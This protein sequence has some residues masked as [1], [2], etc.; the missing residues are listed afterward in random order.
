MSKSA[1]KNAARIDDEELTGDDLDQ[2][3]NGSEGSAPETK[4]GLASGGRRDMEALVDAI[5]RANMVIEF[6]LDGTIID[7][8]ENFLEA[9]GYGLDEIVGRN[10][11]MFVDEI[12]SASR[13]YRQLWTDLRR[14]RF[15]SDTFRRVTADGQTVW[16]QASY[17]PVLDQ[18]GRP[19]RIVKLASDITEQTKLRLD[20]LAKLEAI[21]RSQATVEFEP[22]GTI[23][24]ANDNFLSLMGY[25]AAEVLGKH[26]SIFVPPEDATS[27]QYKEFWASLERGEFRM[28]E[29]RRVAKD[30]RDVYIQGSYNPVF[31]ERGETIKVVK[32]ATDITERVRLR[33]ETSIRQSQAEELNE[34]VISSSQEFSEG[35]R[36]IAESSATLSDAAQSQAASIE[37]MT[38]SI[39]GL[40]ESIGL[41]A[42][43][44][45]E[46][47]GQAS[48]TSQLAVDG[49]RAVSEALDAMRLIEKSSD[50]IGEIIQVIGEISSQT[51]LLALNAAIE[52]ARAGEHG[53][54][55][56]VVAD[57]VRKLAERSSG[58]AKEITTLIKESSRRVGE[59]SALSERAGEA[60][61]RIVAA[62]NDAA[63]MVAEISDQTDHQLASASEVQT[64]IRVIS[65]TTE[66]NAAS[67]E[68]LAAS[69]EELTAQ[70]RTLQDLVQRHQ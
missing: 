15:I 3:G 54:G 49:G 27:P 29:Y 55:F 28:A 31:D 6:E 8:N 68:Q 62:V 37:Q 4:H 1:R 33:E 35:A 65:E 2:G 63:E 9:M 67:S 22:D 66:S 20:M 52:A 23:L 14:G 59:G 38:A 70:A 61:Q 19:L 10:H 30:G 51:N 44:T 25:A 56:A 16:I 32:I 43:R 48:K 40:T 39:S 42:K 46:A 41:V 60:L 18:R 69:A 50:Q 53:L 17:N 45:T 13:E 12:T 36:V 24:S 5:S 26:H 11:S 64:G 57:E 34:E 58:A 47:T 7:A 21:D